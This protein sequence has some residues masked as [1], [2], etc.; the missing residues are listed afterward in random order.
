VYF[1]SNPTLPRYS[2]R[3]FNLPF[4]PFLWDILRST[5]FWPFLCTNQYYGSDILFLLFIRFFLFLD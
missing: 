2:T 4:V 1:L 5:R 3:W